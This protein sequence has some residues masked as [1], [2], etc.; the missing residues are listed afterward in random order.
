MYKFQL[1]S[2]DVD[3]FSCCFDV[4][5]YLG[6]NN[7]R[8]MNIINIHVFDNCDNEISHKLN[9]KQM[10]DIK[11]QCEVYIKDLEE[12]YDEVDFSIL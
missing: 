8:I 4:H 11:K 9:G 5:Q 1:Y 3:A 10:E 7:Y 6:L 2:S 12:T